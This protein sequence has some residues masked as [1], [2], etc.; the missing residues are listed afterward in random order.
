ML[1]F[2]PSFF[3]IITLNKCV[4]AP[5]WDMVYKLKMFRLMTLIRLWTEVK[6]LL[7][8]FTRDH[9]RKHPNRAYLIPLLSVI[10]LWVY[11]LH[12]LAFG[13]IWL[14]LANN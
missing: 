1:D 6:A 7:D 5:A 11:V 13:L 4:N 3:G 2:V 9:I 8:M 14:A 12:W 10:L